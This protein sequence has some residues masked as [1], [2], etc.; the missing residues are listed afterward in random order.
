MTPSKTRRIRFAAVGDLLFTSRPGCTNSGRGLES[1]AEDIQELFASCDIVFANLE[2]TL[3]GPKTVTTEP[4]LVSSEEQVRSLHEAGVNVVTLGNNHAFD[5]FDEG[6]HSLRDLLDDLGITWF[7]AGNNVAE[8]LRPAILNVSG[9]KLAFLGVVDKS[10][11]P[12]HFAGES[13]K[14][15]APIDTEKICRIIENLRGQVNHIIVSPH[16]GEERFRIP[17]P[18]Q[19]RQAQAFV[20][21]GASMVLGHHPHVLQGVEM[22]HGAPI[23]YSLGNFLANNVYW[24][25]GEFLNWDRPGRTGCIF[26]ADI[27]ST[28]VNQWQQVPTFDDGRTVRLD[29][30]RWGRRCLKKLDAMLTAGVTTEAYRREAFHVQTIW[31]VLSHLRWSELRRIRPRHFRKALRMLLRT[32]R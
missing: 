17:S 13:N 18:E 2:A 32:G 14:G 4:R 6:F 8:A 30:S 21:A 22:Y 29:T 23:A 28:G 9:I 12:S 10:S 31:P 24:E 26:I 19:I 15:V 25:N 20:D 16:W 7:G 3:P 1:L 5:C 27:H 11:A